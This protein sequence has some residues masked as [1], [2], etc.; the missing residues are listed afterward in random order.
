MVLT[1]RWHE[2][3]TIITN[4]E[5][6]MFLATVRQAIEEHERLIKAEESAMGT[7]VDEA[8]Y[9]YQEILIINSVM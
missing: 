6:N 1:S 4:D 7:E 2:T 5:F 8:G 3:G 9:P